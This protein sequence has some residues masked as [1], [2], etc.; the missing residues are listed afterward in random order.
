MEYELDIKK[1]K[2]FVH[3][4]ASG[5]RTR[6]NV[7]SIAKEI[8]EACISNQVEEVLVDVRELDG[9]L[10]IFDSMMLI[11]IDLLKLKQR[12]VLKRAAIVDADKRR[13]RFQFFERIAHQRGYNIRLFGDINKALK[14]ICES[15]RHTSQ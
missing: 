6:A 8:F 9:R 15:E 1:E 7:S 12:G 10:S 14:W 3:A 4:R 2:H 13:E 5:K 11:S